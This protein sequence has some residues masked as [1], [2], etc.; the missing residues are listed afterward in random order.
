MHNRCIYTYVIK[1]NNYIY[2]NIIVDKIIIT[3]DEL[4]QLNCLIVGRD[5]SHYERK[6]HV[7]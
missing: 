6:Y 5:V 2:S 4:F 7:V 1:R 3:V